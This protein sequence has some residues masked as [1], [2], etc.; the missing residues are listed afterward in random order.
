V[1]ARLKLRFL[2]GSCWDAVRPVVRADEPTL[3]PPI[4]FAEPNQAA[5]FFLRAAEGARALV[6]LVR[7]RRDLR[8]PLGDA[9][10]TLLAFLIGTVLGVVSLWLAL[11]PFGV[12]DLDRTSS[13]QRHAAV[14]R[15]D[16]LRLVR[17][18]H[19]LQA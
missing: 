15:A 10:R 13:G 7:L 12:G 17:P 14:S 18:G 19:R 2:Q 11:A 8:P 6:A 1:E 3:L 9:A 4:Y 5:F 16:L